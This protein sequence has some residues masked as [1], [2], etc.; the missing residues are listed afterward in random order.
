MTRRALVWLVVLG[1]VASAVVLATRHRLESRY[2]AVEIVLDG[3]DW[4]AL[5]RREGRPVSSVM[6]DLRRRGAVSVALSDNTLKKLVGE[7]AV[8]Y[9]GGGPLASAGRLAALREPFTGLA[10]RGELREDAVY[11]SGPPEAMAFVRGRLTAL[12]GPDRVR[13]LDGAIEVLGTVPDLEEL[14]L[15]FRPADAAPYRTA[16]LEVVLRPRNFRGLT[17]ESLGVMVESYAATTSSPILIFALAEVLGYEGLLTEAA[18]AY[19]Q[20]GVRYGR[21]E[22][23]TERRKQKG[24]DRLTA[25]LRPSVI[26][27]FSITPEELLVLQPDEVVDKFVRAAAERNIRLL[28]LRPLLATPAGTPALEINLGVVETVARELRA[29]GFA[30]GR[31][32]PLP[33]LEVPAPLIWVAALGAAAL[34][35]L[36]MD[37]LAR[38]LGTRVPRGAY[39]VILGAAV[40]LSV[41]AGFTRFDALWRQVLSLATAVAGAAGA[42]VWALPRSRKSGAGA[43]AEGWLT[44][45][46]AAAVATATGVFVAALLSRWEFMLA[47]SAFLGVKVAHVAPVVLV[48]L[49]L[50]FDRREGDW[51]STVHELND[52]VAQPL[53]LGAALAVL[54]AGLAGVMLL[55]RTGNI[56]LPLAG[57]EEQLRTVLE[58]LLVARPRTK[59]FL[60][61]YPALVVAG[62]A[63][64]LGWRRVALAFALVGTIGTAGAIN[65]F[66]HLHTPLVYTVWRTGNA[67]LLGA[68]LAVP[69]VMVLLW[70]SRRPDRS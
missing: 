11:I 12:L 52:W 38:V 66:S 69:A 55:A 18:A 48:A 46:R 43:V 36:V 8:S 21:I 6:A 34:G 45:F 7:G 50:A 26:R 31:A 58:N 28:Y 54:A 23:F 42:T 3:D 62:V 14:G 10:A 25:L 53:R 64:S 49:M 60:I 33:P 2:R 70:L 56:S 37:D 5:I 1:L 57:A 4:V 68:A 19:Q 22:V 16:G 39:G 67:L 63:A 30:T 41:L 65:S 15:G 40:L 17:S 9:A 44:L 24:E 29:L 20:A 35:L 61:G 51:R 32:R 13:A 59:E 27:V 47:F